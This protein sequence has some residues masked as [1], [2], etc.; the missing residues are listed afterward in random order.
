[1]TV[2]NDQLVIKT[3]RKHCWRLLYM[4]SISVKL[5]STNLVTTAKQVKHCIQEC[6]RVQ[7]PYVIEKWILSSLITLV[8]MLRSW[9]NQRSRN[10]WEDEERRRTHRTLRT[11][12]WLQN[13]KEWCRRQRIQWCRDWLCR[14]LFTIVWEATNITNY[15][16]VSKAKTC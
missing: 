16:Y 6:W 4:T 15:D 1:M 11:M 12:S 8:G 2:P 3:S 13:L 7:K 5:Y 10:L 9:W 14:S